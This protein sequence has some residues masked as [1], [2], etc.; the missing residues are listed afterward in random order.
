MSKS[1]VLACIKFSI[2]KVFISFIIKPCTRGHTHIVGTEFLKSQGV[3]TVS[4]TFS[5]WNLVCTLGL[6]ISLQ[7]Q[8][9]WQNNA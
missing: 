8:I 3:F 1:G 9:G 6:K 7:P 4:D 2:L 5:I